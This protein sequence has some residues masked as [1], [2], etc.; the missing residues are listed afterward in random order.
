MAA[1]ITNNMTLVNS[2]ETTGDWYTSTGKIAAYSGFNREGT[3]C[4]GMSVSRT[5]EYCYDT[6][7]SV[8]LTNKIVFSWMLCT[9]AADTQANGGFQIVLGD[10]TNT[11]GYYVGGRDNF[12][13]QVTANQAWSCFILDTSKLSSFSY[14]QHAGSSAPSL[15]AI[16]QI[17]CGCT[18]TSKA[19]GGADNFFWDVIRYI[20]NDGSA[21]LTITGG[22]SGT[23]A[24]FSDI[25][26]DDISTS[27]GKAYGVIRELASGVYELQAPIQFGDDSGTNSIYF[28]DTD[29]TI[30]FADAAVK[31]SYFKIKVVGN[32]T[33]KTYFKL[34][35]K[36]G[37]GDTA[38]GSKGITFQ[39]PS[40]PVVGQFDFSDSD[41]GN[42]TDE[43]VYIYGTKFF[44][45]DGGIILSSDA[46]NGIGHEFIGNTVDSC[47]QVDL[48][49]VVVRNN[50]FASTIDSYGGTNPDGSAILWNSNINIKNCD[51]RNNSDATYDLHAIQHDTAGTF[52]YDGLVFLGND[53]DIHFTPAS[54]DLTINASND[55]NPNT[56]EIEGTGTVTINNAVTV[57]V[58]V[59]DKD[60]NDIQY[61]QVAVYK[62]SDRTEIMNKDTDSNGE[63]SESFNYLSD[64]GIEVRCR[65]ASSGSTKY[66]NFSTL[67][68][69][70]SSGY[71]LLVT[72]EEDPNN[73]ATT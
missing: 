39:A 30:V 36:V 34:G 62:T 61:V 25:E 57:L 54:G 26:A 9:G 22:S 48:G 1:T 13:F 29:A 63:A 71:T 68:T 70:T 32:S 19:L 14:T 33:G 46:T 3:Y 47:G 27:T 73:N 43:G 2:A 20:S 6:V 7:T 59:Q 16:T 8:D 21:A 66:K 42:A 55:A 5:E 40:S 11:R 58:K 37:S 10:G 72:L 65:K 28:S 38:V 50:V 23:P 52:T 53:Y 45:L 31:D 56:S 4:M 17:G 49:R 44:R 35:E 24:T 41:I 15:T 67:G 60:L 51:F 64:T 69:I 12:A 18:T